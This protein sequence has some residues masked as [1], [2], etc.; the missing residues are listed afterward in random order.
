[1]WLMRQAG[2]YLPEYR[3]L[4]EQA[5]GFIAMMRDPQTACEITLQPIRRFGF[6]AAIIFSDILTVP[7]AMGLG[8]RFIE[9]SGPR[10][11][12]TLRSER[13]ITSL[14]DADMDQLRY[15]FDAIALTRESLPRDVPL[16]GFSGSP[17]TLACYMVDGEGG[18]FLQTRKLFQTQP[19][20]FDKLLAHNVRG[21]VDYLTQQAHAGADVLMLFDSWG[22][23]L[24]G[25]GYAR[26][27]LRPMVEITSAI[28]ARCPE[29]PIILF[30]PGVR[31]LQ[32]LREVD[33]DTIGLDWKTDFQ[34]A[35]RILPMA[36]QGN[37]DPAVL[38][39]SAEAVVAH[40]EK[41][42]D[43]VR[44]RTGV[45]VNLGQGIEKETPV[46]NV[47]ALIETVHRAGID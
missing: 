44:G 30:L 26:F 3:R 42:L 38:L 35:A 14:P 12:K 23:L 32:S 27:S 40:T 5:G 22:G 34:Q 41:L 47:A 15:V 10:F 16:I 37:I 19:A 24:P 6:D 7:D 33:C 36:I 46:E 21:I 1:M 29:K 8:L 17:F 9:H 39:G 45:I 11:E 4:R 18:R 13:D 2:R 28:R 20:L 31:D 43:G 25:D